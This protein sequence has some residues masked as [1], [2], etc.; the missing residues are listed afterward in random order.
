MSK[1]KGGNLK[2]CTSPIAAFPLLPFRRDGSE[3]QFQPK[4]DLPW[5]VGADDLS[6]RC[7]PAI[8]VDTTERGVI[9]KVEEFRPKLIVQPF[10][11]P[12]VLIK[13]E[14][15]VPDSGSP[16]GVP[17]GVAKRPRSRV[18]ET[19]GIKPLSHCA[20]SAARIAAGEA[21]RVLTE[22]LPYPRLI[23]RAVVDREAVAARD[24]GNARNLPAPENLRRQAVR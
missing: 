4:L 22:V 6:E 5:V 3:A 2:V 10:G 13:G 12:A 14:I 15:P 24:A 8:R 20:W 16:H 18:L 21:T 19:R 17:A 11:N 1:L 9:E 23:A 7:I